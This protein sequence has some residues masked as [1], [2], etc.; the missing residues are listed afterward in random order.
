MDL[1]VL[2]KGKWG[3]CCGVVFTFSVLDGQMLDFLPKIRKLQNTTM[4]SFETRSPRSS[5][6]EVDEWML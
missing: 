3:L 6:F 1:R 4:C 5:V 2:V